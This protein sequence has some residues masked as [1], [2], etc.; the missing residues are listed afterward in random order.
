[1][2]EMDI[3]REKLKRS[4]VTAVTVMEIA[5]ARKRYTLITQIKKRKANQYETKNTN[6]PNFQSHPIVGAKSVGNDLN[7]YSISDGNNNLL[8]ERWMK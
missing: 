6:F 3:K 7:Y 5:T 2:R 1:M 8:T 4:S